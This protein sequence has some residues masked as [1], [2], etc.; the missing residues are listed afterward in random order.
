MLVN[1]LILISIFLVL[2]AGF[3][4]MTRRK[5]VFKI[6]KDVFWM[7]GLYV[8]VIAVFLQGQGS[9]SALNLQR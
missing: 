9:S 5:R 6:S 8:A 1:I 4:E 2:V 7:L 3:L